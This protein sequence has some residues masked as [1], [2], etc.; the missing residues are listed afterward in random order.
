MRAHPP[1]SICPRTGRRVVLERTE[2]HRETRTGR[3]RRR[4]SVAA[5]RAGGVGMRDAA[6]AGA[7][8]GAAGFA[9]GRPVS[10]RASAA[11]RSPWSWYR[12]SR[13]ACRHPSA[14]APV[15]PLRHRMPAVRRA[16]RLPVRRTRHRRAGA[17]ARC[18][19]RFGM[20]M[21]MPS[22]TGFG[23]ES[24]TIGNTITAATTSA[25]A[26]TR[27]RRARCFLEG[28]DR[29]AVRPIPDARCGA[30]VARRVQ[31]CAP[32]ARSGRSCATAAPRGASSSFLPNEKN[33][34]EW[35]SRNC[36]SVSV[37]AIYGRPA[38][39]QPYGNCRKPRFYH[40][41]MLFWCIAKR[42]GRRR[43]TRDA[44]IRPPPRRPC[45]ARLRAAPRRPRAAG[46]RS[47]THQWS[48]S[49][50]RCCRR[51]SPCRASRRTPRTCGK[52][53]MLP[54][55]LEHGRR[56]R[57]VRDVERDRLAGQAPGRPGSST[58]ARPSRICA[59]TGSTGRSASSAASA[60]DALIS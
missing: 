53:P 24:S 49:P 58:F 4:R 2:L 56:M 11:S 38:R 36:P 21:A 40:S 57:V 29:G 34:H 51:T 7:G 17:T 37:A 12:V 16:R 5:V 42:F 47:V 3:R 27:R 54:V 55:L 1:I 15:Q 50:F 59:D 46:N 43:V 28:S 44:R 13:P 20:S 8:F 33:S 9:T 6:G 25:I 18:A 39:R 32:C 41:R 48:I 10:A 31:W 52:K 14:R 45:A 22:V 60:A 26:P 30:S 35:L 19:G 23:C